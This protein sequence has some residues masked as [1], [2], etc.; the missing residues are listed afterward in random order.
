M[1]V[2]M[3]D[4]RERDLLHQMS[5]SESRVATT[6]GLLRPVVDV[7]SGDTVSF[8]E[9]M[10]SVERKMLTIGD[11]WIVER[12]PET[13][14]EKI[15]MIWERKTVADL[16]S[17][18]RDGRYHEQHDRVRAF[19]TDLPYRFT[20]LRVLEGPCPA[21]QSGLHSI[22]HETFFHICLREYPESESMAVQTIR[23][24]SIRETLLLLHA[25]WKRFAKPVEAVSRTEQEHL[26]RSLSNAKI[27]RSRRKENV[28]PTFVL[29]S[30]LATVPMLSFASAEK[31]AATFHDIS[32]FTRIYHQHPESWREKI[33]T[34]L[35]K[36][37]KKLI[38]RIESL[39][40]SKEA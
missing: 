32:C 22:P 25:V 19:S 16:W 39:F 4:S 21:S 31:I 6:G 12:D 35:N 10:P 26:F 1:I 29:A 38:E 17:S 9:M 2:V 37:S 40:F 5:A 23:T 15:L 11:V 14:G 13:G 36:S 20:Y 7:S 18:V 33:T 27:S 8:Q 3:I 28:T 30:S 24:Y 34:S